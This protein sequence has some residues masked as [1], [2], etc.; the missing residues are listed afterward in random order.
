MLIIIDLFFIC[1]IM[2]FVISFGVLVFGIKIVFIIKLFCLIYNLIFNG[3]DIIVCICLL[4][5]L[6]NCCK[7][8]GFIFKIVIFV[9]SFS[10]ILVVFVFVWLLLIIVI[11]FL[12]IF[13][14]LF[15]RIFILLL[16]FCR[17]FVL[18]W[19]DI[20][21]VI[22]FIGDNNGKDWFGNC[23]VLYVILI[24]FLFIKVCVN[25]FLFVKW[26]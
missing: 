6:F 25:F 1:L 22:L 21:F 13:G 23:I 3:F 9:F 26:R 16:S 10:V 11:L 12:G 19:V 14:M 2:F 18:I 5:K 7:C 15:S 4:N 17:N 24:I 8:F 20:F